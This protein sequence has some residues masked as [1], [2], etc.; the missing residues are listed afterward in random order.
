[1][2]VDCLGLGRPSIP[3]VIDLSGALGSTLWI[4]TSGTIHEGVG[5]ECVTCVSKKRGVFGDGREAGGL[6]C[7]LVC[8]WM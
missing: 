7:T 4:L 3:N 5:V 8:S 2:W 6:F 1:M